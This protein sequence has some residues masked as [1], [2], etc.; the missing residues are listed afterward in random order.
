M[1]QS[2]G[3]NP[4]S[5][6]LRGILRLLAWPLLALVSA[7]C[8]STTRHP[9]SEPTQVILR[10]TYDDGKPMRHDNYLA[11]ARQQTYIKH[12]SKIGSTT[13]CDVGS[14]PLFMGGDAPL[15]ANGE[16]RVTLHSTG[17]IGNNPSSLCIKGKGYVFDSGDWRRGPFH[18]GQ[19]I[20]IRYRISEV[21]MTCPWSSGTPPW[22]DKN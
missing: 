9:A 6:L 5:T 20:E 1:R 11:Q 17:P 15:D 10:F 18:H 13:V 12:C 4:I 21:E 16:V 7:A 19:V 14:D 8:T 22:W 2:P 3:N